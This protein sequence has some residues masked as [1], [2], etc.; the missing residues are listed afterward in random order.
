V[1]NSAKIKLIVPKIE[2]T[3]HKVTP[4]TVMLTYTNGLPAV[5]K[6]EISK[7]HYVNHSQHVVSV[8]PSLCYMHN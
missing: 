1:E 7:S 2:I 6:L 4:E 8:E 5:N 3:V